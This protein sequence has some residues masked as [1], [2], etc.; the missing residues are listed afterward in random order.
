MQKPAR[1][2]GRNT[3][4]GAW[5]Q[6]F[7]LTHCQPF[8]HRLGPLNVS[9]NQIFTDRKLAALRSGFDFL[10]KKIILKKDLNLILDPDEF[11][12]DLD[13]NK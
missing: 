5:K 2:Q 1:K 12:T 9:P 13:F 10:R 3:Q 11:F 4:H 8:K 6:S 7:K